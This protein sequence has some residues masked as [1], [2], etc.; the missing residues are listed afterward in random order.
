MLKSLFEFIKIKTG[1][2]VTSSCLSLSWRR[3]GQW[4][5]ILSFL[6]R[7]PPPGSADH[8]LQLPT[9]Q[10][11]TNLLPL[12]LHCFS[13]A[14]AAAPRLCPATAANGEW[15]CQWNLACVGF[16]CTQEDKVTFD[17]SEWCCVDRCAENNST[18]WSEHRMSFEWVRIK[19]DVFVRTLCICLAK[20][21]TVLLMVHLQPE[22]MW[23]VDIV[24]LTSTVNNIVWYHT[25]YYKLFIMRCI[26]IFKTVSFE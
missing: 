14:T 4:P 24:Y 26:S 9:C 17:M 16:I 25:V 8:V 10:P 1:Q 22:D 2:K 20:S 13:T 7:S 19:F 21:M 3:F 15:W 12:G 23:T 11:A 5:G 18:V 6:L